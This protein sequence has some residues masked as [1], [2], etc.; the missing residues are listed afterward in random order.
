MQRFRNLWWPLTAFATNV[1][2]TLAYAFGW[3]EGDRFAVYMI[4]AAIIFFVV[5]YLTAPLGYSAADSLLPPTRD[6]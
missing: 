6:R 5:R 3:L 1:C 2:L 4:F